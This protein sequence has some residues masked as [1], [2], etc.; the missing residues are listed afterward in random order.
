MNLLRKFYDAEVAEGGGNE[1]IDIAAAMAKSGYNSENRPEH[2]EQVEDKGNNEQAETKVESQAATA[3]VETKVESAVQEAETPNEVAKVET[4]SQV[5]EQPQTIITWQE[6]LKQQQPDTVLKELLGVDD[7]KLAFI[8]GANDLPVEILKL[9]DTWKNKGDVTAYVKEWTTDYSKMSS[10]DVMRNQLKEEYPEASERAIEALF[11]RK[12]IDSYSLDADKY[13]EEE[14]EE[15]RLLLDAE[16]DRYRKVLIAKQKDYVLPAPPE[17]KQEAPD[18]SEAEGMARFESYKAEVSNNPY[19]KDIYT[20]KQLSIGEGEDKFNFPIEP[21][22]ITEVLFDS[23]KWRDTM[24]DKG[25][26]NQ[27]NQIFT[28]KTEHQAL[29]AAVAIY[30]KSFFNE[31]AKHLKAIGGKAVIDPINNAKPVNQ[32]QQSSSDKPPANAAEAMAKFGHMR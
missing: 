12:V 6:V 9:I 20:N 2:K 17:A 11:K 10:E 4:Q 5:V 13:S 28:P 31:Y 22:K 32:A 7:S 1:V 3:S 14:V 24:F 30:G 27:G 19:I 15:G 8:K 25:L 26:D 23:D 18:N 29:V 21:N 16:A